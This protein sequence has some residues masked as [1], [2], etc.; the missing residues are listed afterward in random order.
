MSGGGL[1]LLHLRSLA[2]LI[3][4]LSLIAS[5]C[6]ADL[7]GSLLD[8]RVETITPDGVVLLNDGTSFSLWGL[9]MTDVPRAAALL[10]GHLLSCVVVG[11]TDPVPSADCAIDGAIEVGPSTSQ[12]HLF[13]LLPQLGLA[14][15]QCRPEQRGMTVT[16]P[17]FF[18]YA[19]DDDL[20]PSRRGLITGHLY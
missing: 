20:K 8:G 18:A 2:G 13:N 4:T 19:C 10:S 3:L 7:R 17:V 1:M 12:N 11:S 16:P 6:A 5:S 9:E 15:L 14:S